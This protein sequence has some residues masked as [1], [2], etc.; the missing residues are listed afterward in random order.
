MNNKF[1]K[2]CKILLKSFEETGNI[3]Y[4]LYLESDLNEFLQETVEDYLEETNDYYIDENTSMS[5]CFFFQ[6]K[7]DSTL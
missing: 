3:E 7:S 1:L 4:L 5:S 2:N 6:W